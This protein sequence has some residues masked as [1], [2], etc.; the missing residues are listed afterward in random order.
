METKLHGRDRSSTDLW[1]LRMPAGNG[2]RTGAGAVTSGEKV[3]QRDFWL[4]M[5]SVS[6]FAEEATFSAEVAG[7]Q[8]E[9]GAGSGMAAAALTAMMGGSIENCMDAASVG[10]PEY[11]RA[12]L[13]SGWKPC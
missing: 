10:L 4:R 13:R 11:H 2:H 5:R 1:L 9:C 7:C 6:F 3:V 12:C 8:V